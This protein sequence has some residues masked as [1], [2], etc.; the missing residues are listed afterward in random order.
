MAPEKFRDENKASIS[1]RIHDRGEY[2]RTGL[3]QE[4]T[5]LARSVENI[6]ERGGQVIAPNGEIQCFLH[7][8]GFASVRERGS[9]ANSEQC[10]GY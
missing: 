3:S 2:E 1:L 5:N 6:K 10:C 8:G 4:G 7:T 9:D